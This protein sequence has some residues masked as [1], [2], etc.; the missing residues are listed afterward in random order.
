MQHQH[1]AGQVNNLG[2]VHLLTY[3]ATHL[4]FPSLCLEYLPLVGTQ[5]GWVEL[6]QY[7]VLQSKSSSLLSC[8]HCLHSMWQSLCNGTVS[9]RL[10]VPSINC[11]M[12]LQRVYCC[13]P[14][15]QEIL[16]AAAQCSAANASSVTLS[17]DVRSWTQTWES[18]LSLLFV[19]VKL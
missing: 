17:A 14:A 3:T 8:W 9:V 13:G 10:S 4:A 6:T 19:I 18:L 11:C 7:W 16:I 15:G 2:C 1:V 12:P 5:P